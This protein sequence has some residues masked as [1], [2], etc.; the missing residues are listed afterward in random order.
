MITQPLPVLI[1]TNQ[2]E[3]QIGNLLFGKG[4]EEVLLKILLSYTEPKLM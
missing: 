3:N 1:R 2:S 4:A